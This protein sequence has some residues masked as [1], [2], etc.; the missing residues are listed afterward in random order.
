MKGIDIMEQKK[1]HKQVF[2]FGAGECGRNFY[3]EKKSFMKIVG[4]ID[5]SPK[6]QGKRCLGLPIYSVK[7]FTEL[8]TNDYIVVICLYEDNTANKIVLQLEN[9][10]K[11]QHG[12]NLFICYEDEI[13]KYLN[14]NTFV[15]KKK[16]KEETR[17]GFG[18]NWQNFLK[19]LTDEQIS[20]AE[21]SLLNMLNIQT[22]KGKTFLDVGSGSGLFSLCAR[23][24]GAKV[25]SFDYDLNSVSSTKELKARYYKDDEH[26]DIC[27][28]DVLKNDW[29]N[30]LGK[31]DVVYS[32]G[33]LHHTGAMWSALENIGKLVADGGYLFISIYND[34]GAKSQKWRRI[35]RKYCRGN[36]LIKCWILF[37]VGCRQIISNLSNHGFIKTYKNNR[38][39]SFK[40]DL[41]DWCGGYPFQTA[42]PEQIFDFYFERGYILINLYTQGGGH[43]CNQFVFRKME[44]QICFNKG[45]MI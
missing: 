30:T 18:K 27:N 35:K 6:K 29:L 2:I 37:T 26:W 33:V 4:F 42:K 31:F 13:K 19:D 3:K 11:L 17:F 28:G 9:E 16:G 7:Q 38:G 14:D 10:S 36:Q 15:K 32:W 1:S 5:N 20:I 45:M 40:Y 25:F 23:N 34:Q 41:I 21:E 44:N 39:M 43:G 24:L 22:L 8:K 12:I